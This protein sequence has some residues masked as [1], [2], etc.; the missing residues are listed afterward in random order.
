M[1]RS[2]A[3]NT[4]GTC[5]TRLLA[6]SY[7]FWTVCSMDT[8]SFRQQAGNFSHLAIRSTL[9]PPFCYSLPHLL[10]AYWR[11]LLV[12]LLYENVENLPHVSMGQRL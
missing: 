4:T 6:K 7:G 11:K 2:T 9:K 10:P 1:R 12:N 8:K 3:G 5:E